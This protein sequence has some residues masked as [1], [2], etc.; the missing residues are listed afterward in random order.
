METNFPYSTTE[1][2]KAIGMYDPGINETNILREAWAKAEKALGYE[3]S[4][5]QLVIDYWTGKLIHT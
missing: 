4:S 2:L 3:I 1:I 5:H